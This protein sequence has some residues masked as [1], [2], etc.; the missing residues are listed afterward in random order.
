[1][2][3]EEKKGPNGTGMAQMGKRVAEKDYSMTHRY[4]TT[5]RRD[6]GPDNPIVERKEYNGMRGVGP[7]SGS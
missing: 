2:E 4:N 7:M 5:D 3:G 1:M 6:R